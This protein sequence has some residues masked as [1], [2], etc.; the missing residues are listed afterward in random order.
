MFLRM[1]GEYGALSHKLFCKIS[2]FFVKLKY[3]QSR[4]LT[5]LHASEEISTDTDPRHRLCHFNP[6]QNKPWFL[7]VCWKFFFENTVGK[8]EIAH[9][10]QFLIFPQCFLPF[11]RTFCNFS[12]N[13]KLS[14]ATLSVWKNLK[15]VV[16]ERGKA[17]LAFDLCL[18]VKQ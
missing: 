13:L 15:F 14:S 5:M 3:M 11:S 17:L 7:H 4:T 6:F 9:N 18:K 2:K 12:S 10:K 1:A 8:G 16:W